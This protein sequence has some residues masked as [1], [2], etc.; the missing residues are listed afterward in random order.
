M[1]Y[2]CVEGSDDDVGGGGARGRQNGTRSDRRNSAK[3]RVRMTGL[4]ITLL[5]AKEPT[6]RLRDAVS[7]TY[8]RVQVRRISQTLHC[9]GGWM[10]STAEL[11]TFVADFGDEN[12]RPLQCV[13][14]V[15]VL[16]AA[17]ASPSIRIT[18]S[19]GKDGRDGTGHVD[20]RDV[21]VDV[22]CLAV[23]A[24]LN[25]RLAGLLGE[26]IAQSQPPPTQ[27]VDGGCGSGEKSRYAASNSKASDRCFLMAVAVPKLTMRLPADPSACSSV[28]HGALIRSVHNDTSPVGWAPREAL[29]EVAPG[30]VLEVEGAVVKMAFGSRRTPE[31]TLECTRMICQMLLV[32]GDGARD[33]A[34]GNLMGLYFLEAS[35]SA[36]EAPLKVEYGLAENIRKAGKLGVERHADAD[37]KFLHTWEPN[38]G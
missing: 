28:A 5:L 13:R 35:R 17:S 26:F 18:C 37:L 23:A 4:D 29:G 30:L 1:F 2:D 31:A 34:R 7:S 11:G 20:E 27:P 36:A 16:G 22:Q 9:A 10:H 6:G 14:V 21:V 25:A 38:D 3:V 12:A 32:H 15:E 19:T 33:G 24:T 8:V